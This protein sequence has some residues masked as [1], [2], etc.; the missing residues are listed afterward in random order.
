M[1]CKPVRGNGTLRPISTMTQPHEEQGL[2]RNPKF[3]ERGRRKS[4]PG[5]PPRP[6]PLSHLLLE[7]SVPV[8]TI[9]KDQTTDQLPT[10]ARSA[11]LLAEA[12]C[13]LRR[14]LLR[15]VRWAGMCPR[16]ST[17]LSATMGQAA[18]SRAHK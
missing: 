15:A 12:S 17:I 16:S 10:A 2:R 11:L 1:W 5:G 3:L 18:T 13:M 6:G 8:G 4:R 14:M 9:Y 7:A